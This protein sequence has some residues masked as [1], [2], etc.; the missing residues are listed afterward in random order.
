MRLSQRA[1]TKGTIALLL[2]L[3][4]TVFLLPAV[5]YL[6]YSGVLLLWGATREP[7]TTNLAGALFW[8]SWALG[9]ILGLTGFWLWMFSTPDASRIYRFI[10]AVFVL[11]GVC[12]A[13]PLVPAG[14]GLGF[15][16]QA[17]GEYVLST[18]VIAVLSTAVIGLACVAGVVICLWLV[19]PGFPCN[20][21]ARPI[22]AVGRPG[23]AAHPK[24][25]GQHSDD[26]S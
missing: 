6:L 7:W 3:P 19:A 20:P 23:A 1:I 25:G 14:I 12:S 2:G 17:R 22:A 11:A 15:S 18:A 4:V 10:T 8:F 21:D 26:H 9:G 16:D 5:C 24:A 13:A